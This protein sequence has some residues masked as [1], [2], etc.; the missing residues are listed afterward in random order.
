VTPPTPTLEAR[1]EQLWSTLAGIGRMP[2]APGTDAGYARFSWT[3]ADLEL[4]AWFRAEAT[5]LGLTIE[6]DRNGN[7]WAWWDLPSGDRDGAIVTGSH[8]DSV[9]GGGAFDGPLGVVSGLL[10]VEELRR[11][12][13]EPSRP[14]AVVDFT[15]EEGARFGVP[16][17]GSRLLTGELDP[18]ATLARRD[19]AGISLE[20]ALRA[21]GEDPAALGPD[22]D[23]LASVAAYVELHVEQGRGLGPLRE[24]LG[25]ATGIWPHGRWRFELTG[26]PNHAGTTLIEDRH[27]PVIVLSDLALAAR[28]LA[29]ETGGRATVAKAHVVPNV[30]NGIPSSVTAWLDARGADEATVRRLVDEVTEVVRRSADAEGVGVEIVNETFTAVVDFDPALRDRVS[31]ILGGVPALPTAAGH[32]AGSLSARIPTAMIFVRNET[33]A[34]HTP[35]ETADREDCLIGVRALADVLAD[36]AGEQPTTPGPIATRSRA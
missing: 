25:V 11:R 21:A 4:R 1:F 16:C 29:I 5:A 14:I 31:G 3:A 2:A 34:S 12:G 24:P 30:T 17:M 36:L 28:R 20:E 19:N 9:P 10:A 7:I 15:D 23:L 6:Q 13:V 18:A 22:P 35:I 27:D 33:G 26:E 8:L 32:D